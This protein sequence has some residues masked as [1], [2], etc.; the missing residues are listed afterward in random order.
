[1]ALEV[2]VLERPVELSAVEREGDRA[3]VD[4]GEHRFEVG[5][6]P[7]DR[8]VPRLAAGRLNGQD[9]LERGVGGERLLDLLAVQRDRRC[10]GTFPY[11][12][13]R[14]DEHRRSARTSALHGASLH[15]VHAPRWCGTN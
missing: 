3:G 7:A 1:M 10:V 6:L 13:R 8:H 12:P 15:F 2:R 11:V 9:Q 4:A 14:T 5:A